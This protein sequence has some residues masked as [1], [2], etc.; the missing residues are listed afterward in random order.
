MYLSDQKGWSQDP[1]LSRPHLGLAVEVRG[2]LARDLGVFLKVSSLFFP[3]FLC[4]QLLHVGLFSFA[5]ALDCATPLLSLYFSSRYTIT[6]L[7]SST[8][9][10]AAWI[11]IQLQ[12]RL[13]QFPWIIELFELEQALKGH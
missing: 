12:I 2:S 1:P 13:E 11:P 5:T 6:S 7:Y 3:L 9:V 4:P 8:L 10:P